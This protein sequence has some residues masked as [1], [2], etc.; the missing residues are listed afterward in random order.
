M[1]VGGGIAQVKG[2]FGVQSGELVVIHPYNIKALALTLGLNTVGLVLCG[3]EC[4]VKE[5]NIVT[6]TG[7]LISLSLDR[8]VLGTVINPLGFNLYNNTI[9]SSE[10]S[11]I[12]PVEN[13]AP[14]ILARQPIYEPLITG[15]TIIDSLVPIGRG[16]RELVIGDRQ[17]G[18]LL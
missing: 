17:T 4:F 9:I 11:E 6:I 18:R 14:D 13:D 12:F 8:S 3:S 10:N 5:K 16:Q 7:E 15:L 2:L 1:T